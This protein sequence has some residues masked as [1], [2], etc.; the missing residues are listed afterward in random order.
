MNKFLYYL[1][2]DGREPSKE[3]LGTLS[4][5]N[6]H[7]IS[8]SENIV[9][10]IENCLKESA[11]VKISSIREILLQFL[12]TVKKLTNQSEE[13]EYMEIFNL[14]KDNSEYC[15][16]AFAIYN[17]FERFCEEIF[18]EI[19]KR[20]PRERIKYTQDYEG[21]INLDYRN[22]SYSYKVIDANKIIAVTMEISDRDGIAFGY[23]NAFRK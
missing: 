20:I 5:K 19:D 14:I 10:W 22:I 16:A 4:V 23:T 12:A 13:A 17:N 8:F 3:S 15:Q 6:V 11:T 2:L 9:D 1:T 18:N 21:Q 7:C